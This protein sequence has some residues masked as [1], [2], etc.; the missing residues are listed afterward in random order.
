MAMWMELPQEEIDNIIY[1]PS[2]EFANTKLNLSEFISLCK[3]VKDGDVKM[4]DEDL[5]DIARKSGYIN[6]SSSW[7]DFKKRYKVEE[8]ERQNV[9]AV[10]PRRNGSNPFA[11]N[12][13]NP[14]DGEK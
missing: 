3:A 9:N 4:L 10:L 14:E 11:Q 1:I 12:Q 2:K 5:Y 8:Q 6:V 7:D 13:N